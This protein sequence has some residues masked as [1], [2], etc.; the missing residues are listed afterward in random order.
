MKRKRRDV[1]AG[2]VVAVYRARPASAKKRRMFVPGR[3]RTGGYYGRFASGGE[4]KFHDTTLV[5]AVVANTGGILNSLNLIAQGVTESQRIGRKCTV[6]SVY[7]HYEVTMPTQDAIAIPI[8]GDS[9]R[10]IMYQD[11]QTNGA[12]ATAALLLEATVTLQSFRNLANQSRFN[13]L[14]D[15]VHT[16]NYRGMNSDGAGLTS[17]GKVVQ[18]FKFYKKCNIPLEFDD[19][20][21]AIT[22]LRTNNIGIL[23]I[24]TNG[25]IGFSSKIRLR[26]SDGN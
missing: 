24:S 4:L 18:E 2:N 7:W 6:K 15:K 8:T 3:D 22:E 1:A 11:K 5:D 10:C 21:G 26:F 16:L 14:M 9:V 25:I 23:L 17:Q 19:T 13:I 12:T 20:T